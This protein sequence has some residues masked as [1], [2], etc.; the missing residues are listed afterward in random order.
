[1]RAMT[2]LNRQA[3]E[4]LLPS[5]PPLTGN[6]YYSPRNRASGRLGV[7]R[8][9]DWTALSQNWSISWSTSNVTRPLI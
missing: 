5:F 4:A 1:M 9:P 2:G 8:K 7:G 6:V 3:F